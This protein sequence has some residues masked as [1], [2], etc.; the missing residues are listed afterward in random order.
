MVW[1]LRSL[2]VL[3]AFVGIMLPAADSRA[4]FAHAYN[5]CVKV[6]HCRSNNA[7]LITRVKLVCTDKEV[8]ASTVEL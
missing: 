8:N 5:V 6:R 2:L 3:L 4:S 7:L 1:L